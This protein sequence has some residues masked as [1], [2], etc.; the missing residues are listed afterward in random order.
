MNIH[1]DVSTSCG[2]S[3]LR[4]PGAHKRAEQI[5]PSQVNLYEVIFTFCPVTGMG[6]FRARAIWSGLNRLA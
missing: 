2:I 5:R 1:D 3:G 6:M 4:Q